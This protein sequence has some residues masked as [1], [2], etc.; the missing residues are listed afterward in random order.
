MQQTQV[1]FQMETSEFF[2][3]MRR[4]IED[5]LGQKES[6]RLDSNTDSSVKSFLKVKDVCELFQV[7]KPTLYQWMN[8]GKIKSV[9]IQSRRYFLWKDINE[10]IQQNHSGSQAAK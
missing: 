1:L 10:L 8:D 6:K 4:M 2:R 7:S 9:K 5:A 3:Q